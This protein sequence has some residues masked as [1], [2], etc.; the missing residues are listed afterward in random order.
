MPEIPKTLVAFITVSLFV[1]I[2]SLSSFVIE[3]RFISGIF[4][5]ERQVAALTGAGSGLVGWWK[6]DETTGSTASDSSGNS[7]TGSGTDLTW[8]TG[9]KGNAVQLN[10]TS[11]FVEVSQFDTSLFAVYDP[12]FTYSAWI[13]SEESGRDQVIASNIGPWSF[14][15]GKN[16]QNKISTFA[17]WNGGITSSGQ[18]GLNTWTH[19]A[20]TSF[21]NVYIDGVLS[22]LSSASIP[23]IT[24]S[25]G[26]TIGRIH[27]DGSMYWK[28]KIDDLRVYNRVLTGSE[29]E[30][31][32]R[33]DA[34]VMQ[35]GDTLYATS[36]Q[37]ADVSAAIDLA[38]DGQTVVVPAGTATW[39]TPLS[40]TKR[41]I[42]KGAGIGETVITSAIGSDL[43]L[44]N[45][46]PTVVDE[47]HYFRL[48]GFTFDFNNSS[49]SLLVGNSNTSQPLRMRIDHNE[50]LDCISAGQNNSSFE[51]RGIVYGVFDN[52]YLTGNPLFH[53]DGNQAQSWNLLTFSFGS[54]ENFYVEDNVFRIGNTPTAGGWGGRYAVRYNTYTYTQT[55]STL[56]PWFDAHGNQGAGVYALMGAEIYGNRIISS[57]SISSVSAFNQR[58]GKMLAFFNSI[59]NF[60]A[61]YVPVWEEYADVNS[62]TTNSQPQYVSGSYYFNNQTKD[63]NARAGVTINCKTGLGGYGPDDE[64]E[65]IQEN[66]HFFN[67][68][69]NFDGSSGI[70]I[71]NIS[72]RPS[73]CTNGAGYW[74][75]EQTQSLT[76]KSGATPSVAISG[77][78]YVC[79]QSN[80]WTAYFTP[81]QYP[82]PMRSR[83]DLFPGICDVSAVPYPVATPTPT[84]SNSVVGGGGSPSGDGSGGGSSYG[85]GGS[86]S[87]PQSTPSCT[88][89]TISI[90]KALIPAKLLTLRY[91]MTSADVKTL[92]IFLNDKGFTVSTTGPGSKGQ[93]TFYFGPATQSALNKYNSA[94][95]TSVVTVPC[96]TTSPSAGATTPSTGVT[97]PVT[98]TNRLPSTFRFT[99][100]LPPN[101]TS[102]DVKNLQ[103]FLNDSGF[104]VSTTGPGSKGQET[105]YFGP[106]TKSAVIRFQEYYKSEVLT[107]NGLLKGTGLF[108]PASLKKANG[109][110][111]R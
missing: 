35:I 72:A 5:G 58:G 1:G 67:Q 12:E 50:F 90:T 69:D 41:I 19:V 101:T 103:I 52:N 38:T 10:G 16:S 70:G 79:G 24:G 97:T 26:M 37:L 76:G 34:T 100:S 81:Y 56:S 80:N 25:F 28:G 105:F 13:Y 9:K 99:R 22:T 4:I 30:E 84:P 78:L 23:W 6:F 17:P 53:F 45:Y 62:P 7:F 87:Q 64:C 55:S 31:L 83:C 48:T 109:V 106:A 71:G 89:R 32:S 74:A 14:S 96:T 92:Q 21:G 11:S 36:P 77:T 68:S 66:I 110:L 91:G 15:F 61:T 20:I 39:S 8:T 51:L 63:G 42:L 46:S 65:L 29:I 104:T 40:I 60:Y 82:H 73:V 95:A 49:L 47:N 108:G 102:T 85:S 3:D 98:G 111:G 94:P 93:E 44:I 86:S 54:S 27:Q 59:E 57:D 88:P 43:S 33:V 107:P 18:I 75:T 2:C